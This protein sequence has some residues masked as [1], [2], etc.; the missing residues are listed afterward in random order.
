MIIKDWNTI[1]PGAFYTYVQLDHPSILELYKAT[2]AKEM[3]VQIYQVCQIANED[4]GA[5]EI[6][7]RVYGM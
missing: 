6:L 4:T 5:Y 1:E 2:T 3:S 7:L